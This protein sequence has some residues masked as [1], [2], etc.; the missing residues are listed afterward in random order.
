MGKRLQNWLCLLLVLCMMVSMLPVIAAAETSADVIIEAEDCAQMTSGQWAEHSCQKG[1][2]ASA[3]HG[4]FSF[5]QTEVFAGQSIRFTLQPAA[6]TYEIYVMSKDN[7]DRAIFQFSLGGTNIGDPVDQ[8]NANTSGVFVEHKIGTATFSG[9]AMQLTATLTGRN[10]ANTIRYGGTFDYFRLVPVSGGSQE[11]ANKVLYTENFDEEMLDGLGDGWERVKLKSG[12][13]LQGTSASGAGLLT[14]LPSGELPEEY[15]IVADM[16]LMQA[17]S[18]SGYSAGVTF[19]HKDAKNFYHFRLDHSDKGDNAQLYQWEDGICKKNIV[20]AKGESFTGRNEAHRLR[21]TVSKTEVKCYVDGKSVATYTHEIGTGGKVG[22]R[23]YNAVALFDNIV[24]KSGVEEP[25]DGEMANLA[26]KSSGGEE[27]QAILVNQ[28]GYDNGT[29]MRATIPNAEGKKFQ[30][31]Q[32]SGKDDVADTQVF[33]GE[34]QDG[35]ADFTGKL[36]PTTDTKYYIQCGD[37]KSYDFE[38]G[39]NLLQRRTVRQALDFMVQTRSDKGEY[40]QCGIAWRDSHQFS[41]ELNGLVLQY[42]ANPS[43]YDNMEKTIFTEGTYAGDHKLTGTDYSDLI[44]EDGEQNE[45]DMLVHIAV[46]YVRC[47]IGK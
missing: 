20:N 31:M 15:T 45:P 13:A 17:R 1:S 10:A 33:E 38:V 37:A 42:M 21:V 8:Y 24:V 34:V 36:T 26:L 27:T 7:P 29:S 18:S 41:F 16:A 5:V 25:A 9:E 22:L 2:S 32:G 43:V 3:E 35:I 11:P 46:I 14:A 4:K 47:N 40:G 30:V 28:I 12:Y 39:T 6:G 44:P 23:V 19:Q